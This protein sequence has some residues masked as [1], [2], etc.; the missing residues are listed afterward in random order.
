MTKPPEMDMITW[1]CANLEEYNALFD[2]EDGN[3]FALAEHV[4]RKGFLATDEARAFVAARLRGDKKRRGVKRTV[5]Q[6]AK[7]V[8]I[9]GMVRG[10]QRERNCSE[11]A[12]CMLFLEQH[13]NI[14]GDYD[15]LRTHLRRAKGFFKDC[16]GRE[17]APLV[18][19]SGNSE[20][21]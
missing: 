15:A 12:A 20:R 10:I 17:P 8:G 4:E 11:Y 14:C 13:S 1:L 9:L 16:L 21:R 18:Q 19:K 7:E 6:Q 5:A 3:P 2:A